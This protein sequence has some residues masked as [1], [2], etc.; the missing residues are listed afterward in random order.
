MLDVAS[1][2]HSGNKMRI[3]IRIQKGSRMM[4]PGGERAYE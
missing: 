1:G 4:K 3:I 2:E